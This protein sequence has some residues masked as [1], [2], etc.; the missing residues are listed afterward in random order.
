LKEQRDKA[1]EVSAALSVSL[2]DSQTCTCSAQ[3]SAKKLK[4]ELESTRSAMVKQAMVC[5]E[6]QQGLS[7]K[8]SK[9]RQ[10]RHLVHQSLDMSW[11]LRANLPQGGPSENKQPA[12]SNSGCQANTDT[13]HVVFGAM[14]DGTGFPISQL[15]LATRDTAGGGDCCVKEAPLDF[16]MIRD[17]TLSTFFPGGRG[18]VWGEGLRCFLQIAIWGVNVENNS[19]NLRHL[20]KAVQV[21]RQMDLLRCY[22]MT[23]SVIQGFMQPTV[24]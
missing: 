2:A 6:L 23:K 5:A 12:A 14:Q 16:S 22:D 24:W 10:Q 4:E 7:R 9:V 1:L 8:S 15:V 21:D 17:G 11:I 18:E 20:D 19:R 3:E 13:G